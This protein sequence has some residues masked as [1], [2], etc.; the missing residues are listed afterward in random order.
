M[1]RFPYAPVLAV[2]LLSAPEVHITFLKGFR[3]TGLRR[4]TT[5]DLADGPVAISPVDSDSAFTVHDVVIGIGFH[6]EQR[7][8]LTFAGACRL[9]ADGDNVVVINDIDIENYLKSVISSEMSATASPA[10]L[11]AHAV[12]SRSW[13]LAQILAKS[14]S[15]QSPHRQS[16]PAASVNPA[17]ARSSSVSAEDS[18][19]CPEEIIRWYDHDD[20]SLFDVCADDHC[21]RYQG[22]TRITTPEASSAVDD[23]R[24]LV[25]TDHDGNLCDARFS[26]CCGGAMESFSSCWDDRDFHY[27]APLRDYINPADLPDLRLHDEAR[28]WIMSRPEAWCDCTSPDILAQVLNNF[29]LVTKDFYRWQVTYTASRLSEL[30]RRRSG[31]DLGLVSDIEPLQRGGSGRIIRLRIT[32]SLRTVIIGKELEIRRT[33][34]ESH[35]Y[36][37]AFTVDKSTG[38]DGETLFTLNGAGWGHGVGLCQ[39]GAAVMATRGYTHPAILS[40]YYPGSTLTPA[41]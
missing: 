28:R 18:T 13:A 9:V 38:P 29:D 27:L 5:A 15:G 21:Q 1:N 7:L 11:R 19:S 16:A 2:G 8:D 24:G 20:H 31:I 23:T 26:K 40:H 10:L 39:I 41:W 32:G 34:S 6:W 12:I 4:F 25:L 3:D 35:L 30:I 36:S 14:S 37:S 33:L 22:I 17:P